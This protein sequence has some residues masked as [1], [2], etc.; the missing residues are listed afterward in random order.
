MPDQQN[1][2][3]LIISIIIL[4]I[5]IVLIIIVCCGYNNNNNNQPYLQNPQRAA[6]LGAGAY[7][8]N[9]NKNNFIDCVK[10]NNGCQCPINSYCTQNAKYLGYD[11]CTCI[12]YWQAW[13][14]PAIQY[15]VNNH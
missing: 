15:T 4:I 1:L 14:Q 7:K 10:T 9:Q 12:T 13:G 2:A 6:A 3:S 11:N 5:V 8:Y